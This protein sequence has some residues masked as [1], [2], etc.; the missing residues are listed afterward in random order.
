MPY[1][2]D[3]PGFMAEAD[4]KVM[5][6]LAREVPAGGAIV[7]VGSWLGQSTWCWAASAPLA[8]IY[9]IDLWRWMPKDYTGPGAPLPAKADPFALFSANTAEHN[10]IVPLRRES[11]GGA[12]NNGPVDLVFI[13]AMHQDPW[14]T[15][16]VT[17]WEAHVKPG[18]IICG[19]DFSKKFP[20]VQGAARA[21]AARLGAPLE[22]PGTKFWMVRRPH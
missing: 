22:T 15:N 20:A 13:D 4:L 3:I 8:T 11:S 19:D 2:T 10:N 6:Q 18:G 7:E 1:K 14:V 21:C 16:D 17:F 9:A 5:E 12:W